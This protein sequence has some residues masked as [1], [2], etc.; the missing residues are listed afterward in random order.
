[1]NVLE[2][3]LRPAAELL[4][5][6]IRM[7][8]PARELCD[9]LEG[10]VVAVRLRHTAISLYFLV[11]AG[12]IRPTGEFDG[13]PDVVITGSLPALAR[14][15]AR[16]GEQ[17]IRD[18]SLELAGDADVARLFQQLLRYGRPDLEEELAGVVGDSAAHGLGR[19]ARGL[20][21]WGRRARSTFEQNVAEYLQE[22]SRAVP[23]R[24]EGEAFRRDLETLRDDV[25]RFDARLRRLEST[26]SDSDDDAGR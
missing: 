13:E 17:A 20:G 8:T 10:R 7:K 24:H 3:L 14:L 16:S 4:N 15:A 23:G 18:G 12:S 26:A 9:E 2:S 21:E 6:Q 5:R 22:E 25:E 11:E 1:M 19:F